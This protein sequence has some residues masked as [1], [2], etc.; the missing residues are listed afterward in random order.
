MPKYTAGDV[1]KDFTFRTPFDRN[2]AAQSPPSI[3]RG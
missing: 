1:M 2:N 3:G